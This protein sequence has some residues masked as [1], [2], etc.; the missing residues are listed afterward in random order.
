MVFRKT[1]Q[2]F[3]REVYQGLAAVVPLGEVDTSLPLAEVYEGRGICGREG[4]AELSL[5][6]SEGTSM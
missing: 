3:V 4:R 5:H 2:G 6:H 1:K